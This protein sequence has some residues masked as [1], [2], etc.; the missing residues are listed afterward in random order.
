MTDKSLNERSKK[1]G[2]K[3]EFEMTNQQQE[4]ENP[5]ATR[6]DFGVGHYDGNGNSQ[7][8]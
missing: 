5:K 1:T 2:S 8:R 6:S 7:R 4:I 3:R